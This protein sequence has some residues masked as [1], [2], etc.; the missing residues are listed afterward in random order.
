MNKKKFYSSD[1]PNGSLDIWSIRWIK[2]I[3]FYFMFLTALVNG[4]GKYKTRFFLFI[5]WF[6]LIK[7]IFRYNRWLRFWMVSGFLCS[8]VL[9]TSLMFLFLSSIGTASS[10]ILYFKMVWI[11]TWTT[12]I[13]TVS[14]NL[15][16][17]S[18]WEMLLTFIL[19]LFFRERFPEWISAWAMKVS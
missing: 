4:L 16:G 5:K 10:W 18:S 7:F 9:G 1:W 13:S 12:W 15:F 19:L 3:V 2:K 6:F 8:I 11:L 17:H 14:T